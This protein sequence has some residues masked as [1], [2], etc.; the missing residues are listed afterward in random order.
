MVTVLHRV[1]WAEAADKALHVSRRFL[2]LYWALQEGFLIMY[3]L[4]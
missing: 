2:G 1:E 4:Q 3:R